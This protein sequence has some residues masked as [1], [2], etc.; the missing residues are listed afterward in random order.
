M[1]AD[2]RKLFRE[3]LRKALSKADP[4]GWHAVISDFGWHELLTDDPEAA[5]SILL[6]LQGT[7]LP[8]S[9]I[10]DDV[11]LSATG[12]REWS[13]GGE[14]LV[15]VVYPPMG[16]L[17]PASTA[18][19]TSE[20][21]A[22]VTLAGM[23]SIDDRAADKLLVPAWID[24]DLVIV[25][26]DVS[27]PSEA[28]ILSPVAIDPDSGWSRIAGSATGEV[29]ARGEAATNLAQG[30]TAA[31][32]RALAHELS[33]LGSAMLALTV[34]HVSSRS[35]FGHQLG[36]F[37]A[38]KHGLADTRVWQECAELAAAAAWEDPEIEASLLAKSLSGRF[39]RSAAENCQQ[40]L[41]GMGFTWEHPF[42][43]LLRRGL[44]LEQLVGTTHAVYTH[45]GATLKTGAM[46]TLAQL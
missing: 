13:R 46:P 37:Q 44:I 5:V 41:G 42:R 28:V 27:S 18:A 12:V 4:K 14:S 33:A 10:I 40:Y 45:L 34:D 35:Q 24:D 20:G 29:A 17:E 32:Q 25:L 19:V 31:A 36:S 26:V 16:R 3:S 21:Q 9:S 30:I 11:A 2:D 7:L 1:D 22:T 43:G 39:F 23:V 8:H 38:V 6:D 15:R